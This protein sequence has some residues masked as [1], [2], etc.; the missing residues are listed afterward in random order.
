MRE[1]ESEKLAQVEVFL[2]KGVEA[3]TV[4]NLFSDTAQEEMIA[5][6]KN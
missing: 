2:N 6:S 5:Y 3:M 4:V 1:L